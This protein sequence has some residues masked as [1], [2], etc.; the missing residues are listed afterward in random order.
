MEEITNLVQEAKATIDEFE[1]FIFENH[2]GKYI[3]VKEF[4]K[5]M[6][7]RIGYTESQLRLGSVDEDTKD[8]LESI[9][10][11]VTSIKEAFINGNNV[12]IIVDSEGHYTTQEIDEQ[13][14]P[15]K[16][17]DF[18]PI[19]SSAVK[20][21]DYNPEEEKENLIKFP[22]DNGNPLVEEMVSPTVDTLTEPLLEEAEVP[23]IE[24]PSYEQ[25]E[26]QA[27]TSSEMTEQVP[28]DVPGVPDFEQALDVAAIDAFL[29]ESGIKENIGMP[30]TPAEP[31][32]KL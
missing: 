29:N 13:T 25:E 4:T 3:S 9:I 24:I 27:S 28:S 1:R 2:H 31:A 10:N 22:E 21:T 14:I 23:V 7:S 11:D 20:I 12:E 6:F 30:D 17:D 16:F 5:R 19:E 8:K 15:T 26:K 32:L 18:K